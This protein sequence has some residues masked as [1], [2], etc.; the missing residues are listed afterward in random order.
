[1]MDFHLFIFDILDISHQFQEL[2]QIIIYIHFPN[3]KLMEFF[4]IVIKISIWEIFLLEILFKLLPNYLPCLVLLTSLSSSHQITTLPLKMSDGNSIFHAPIIIMALKYFLMLG[5]QASTSSHGL[6]SP[7]NLS[8]FSFL[9]SP[10]IFPQKDL[11]LLWL[12]EEI[13]EQIR[14]S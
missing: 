11:F 1:M 4:N 8:V 6:S 7:S 2:V 12:L 13:F 9:N 3:L 14:D 5:S 10:Y